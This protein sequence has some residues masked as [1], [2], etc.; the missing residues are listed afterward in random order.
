MG[1]FKGELSVMCA[2]CLLCAFMYVWCIWKHVETNMRHSHA[3]AHANTVNSC[4][5]IQANTDLKRP[6]NRMPSLD[7]KVCSL[8]RLMVSKGNIRHTERLQA[9]G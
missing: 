7:S 9:H 4:T 6:Q 8:F 2:S 1:F 3:N 5:Q